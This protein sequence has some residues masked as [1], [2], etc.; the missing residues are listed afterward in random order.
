MRY[1]E[2]LDHFIYQTNR[3]RLITFVVLITFIKTGIWYMP[4]INGWWPMSLN[5]FRNPF[6]D[7][8]GQYVFWNWLGPFLAWLLHIR[9]PT[10]FMYFHLCFAVAFTVAF[11]LYIFLN[12]DERGARTALVL[13]VAFPASGM[14]YFW[15][16]MDSITLALMMFILLSR[17]RPFVAL[18]LGIALGMQ[19]AEQGF[20][21]Y[22]AVV[23]ALIFS[24]YYV[25]K[26]RGPF[27]IRWAVSAFV[28][29]VLGKLVL[30]FLFRHL[31]IQITDRR[32]YFL[33]NYQMFLAM[34]YY[35]V[36]YICW[37]FFGAAWFAVIKFA[38]RGKASAGFLISVAGLMLLQFTVSD[39]TRV[40]AM[41]SF[42][43][44]AVYLLLSSDFLQSLS[45][46]LVSWIFAIWLI[47]PLPY[48]WGGRP[49]ISILPY[50]IVFLLHRLFGWFSVPANPSMWP[51]T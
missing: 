28:G 23:F 2:K 39:E 38:E 35:H 27:S 29:V 8:I 14:G 12:F 37:S 22:G 10:S 32:Y 36:Q 21:A 16:G 46:Q 41:V 33:H 3:T 25:A 43:L 47:V 7:P 50:N 6:Q 48:A 11:L 51:L 42:P 24:Y 18:L 31:G 4:N 13:F 40:F 9:N 1:I 5:P 45:N 30:I 17:N 34:F 26:T 44:V 15:I 20:F 19:H 49:L